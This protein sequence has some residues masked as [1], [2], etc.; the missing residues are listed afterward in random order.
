[1]CEYTVPVLTRAR[2][3]FHVRIVVYQPFLLQRNVPTILEGPLNPI[4]GMQKRWYRVG[5]VAALVLAV[6]YVI[7]TVLYARV[8]VPPESGED[9]FKYLSGKATAW[10]AILAISVFTDFLYIPVAFALYLALRELNRNLMLLA[11]VFV[12][13]F[14]VLDLAVT[15]SHYASILLLYRN[16]ISISD[17]AHRASYVAAADYA[18]AILRSPL[19]IVYAIVTLSLG[20]LFTG[21]VM[22]RGTF[23]KMTAYLALG[24]GVLGILSLTSFSFAIIGNAVLAPLWLF[25]VGGKLWRLG[26]ER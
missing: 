1:M 8:G 20:I 26:Q 9:W 11:T 25:F 13:L 10:W 23:G 19:E 6:G 2:P 22:L 4:C 12:G 18:S 16:Y 24:T 3:C 21:F 7:I 17:E 15:W 5:G 14:V